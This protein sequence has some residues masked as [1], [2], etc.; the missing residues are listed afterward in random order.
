MSDEE[1]QRWVRYNKSLALAEEPIVREDKGYTINKKTC[2][3]CGKYR[4]CKILARRR[5]IMNGAA[6]VEAFDPEKCPSWEPP[7]QAKGADPKNVKRLM[8]QFKRGMR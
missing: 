4:G 7:K 6:T 3:K 1:H 8:K 5:R 2:P